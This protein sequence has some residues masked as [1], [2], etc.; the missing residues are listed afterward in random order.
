ML[1]VY[2]RDGCSRCEKVKQEFRDTAVL[3]EEVVIG[4]DVDRETVLATFPGVKALPIVFD[5]TTGVIK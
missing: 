4:R 2:T 1:K 5:P 3:Y